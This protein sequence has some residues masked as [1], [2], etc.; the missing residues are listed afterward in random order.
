M[1]LRTI[2]SLGL[3]AAVS[4]AHSQNAQAP[5]ASSAPAIVAPRTILMRGE[6]LAESKRL[7]ASGNAALK[8]TF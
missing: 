7:F 5:L 3:S 4:S 2:A 6:R 8:P 1:M